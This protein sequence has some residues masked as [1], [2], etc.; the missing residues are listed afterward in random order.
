MALNT[1]VM[2]EDQKAYKTLLSRGMIE[3]DY[4]TTP[5][6]RAAWKKIQDELIKRMTGKLW[7]KELLEKVQKTAAATPKTN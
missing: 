5:E 7:S 3:F 4:Q 2:S 1:N 6:Q